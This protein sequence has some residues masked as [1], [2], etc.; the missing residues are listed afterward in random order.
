MNQDTSPRPLSR[1]E[2]VRAFQS[3]R[4]RERKACAY[5]GREMEGL[6]R[7]RFCSATCR[8][9]AWQKTHRERVNES[10]RRRRQR[11]ATNTPPAAEGATG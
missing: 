1:A 9:A 3:L 11:Q 5:C 6:R 7:R 2:I 4:K 10:R 8:S